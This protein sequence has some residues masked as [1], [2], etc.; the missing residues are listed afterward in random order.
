MKGGNLTEI[1]FNRRHPAFS[2]IFG[3]INT[4]DEDVDELGE[5][6]VLERLRRAIN[7]TKIIFAAWGRYEREAGVDRSRALQK[8]RNDWGQIA[9]GFLD[10][11]DGTNL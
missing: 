4:I 9:A 11:E 10:P 3:T 2:D 7:A 5:Q 6:E 1:I 8:V